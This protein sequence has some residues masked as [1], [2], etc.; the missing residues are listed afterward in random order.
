MSVFEHWNQRYL[1]G[2]TPWDSGLVSKE[3]IRVVK[4]SQIAPCRALELGC[5]T[6][7][8]AVWLA[9]Q[10]FAVTA[11]DCSEHAIDAA[12]RK[13]EASGVDVDFLCEDVCELALSG[14]PFPFVFDRGC[15]HCARR[16][17]REGILQVLQRVTGADS[18]YL[19]LTGNANEVRDHG[20]PGLFEDDVRNELGELFDVEFI[21]AFHFEDP[22]GIRGPLGWSCLLRRST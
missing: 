5:G 16:D 17:N 14:K 10:G 15:Y 6:G 9:E 12:R 2:N 19:V 20:P 11:V 4:E 22:G 1:D 13:A 21:R 7:T 3:L 8:N 18:T